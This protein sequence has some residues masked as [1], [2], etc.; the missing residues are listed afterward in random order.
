[1]MAHVWMSTGQGVGKTGCE[2][3]HWSVSKSENPEE[4]DR[5]TNR[6]ACAVHRKGEPPVTVSST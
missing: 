6:T 5:L 4:E 2:V 1:M 3:L